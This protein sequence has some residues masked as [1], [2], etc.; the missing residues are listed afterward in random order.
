MVVFA[1]DGDEVSIM[2]ER[3]TKSFLDVLLK[4]GIPLNEPVAERTIC[5]EYP[6]RNL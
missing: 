5:N 6:R 4:A 1:R 2:A 3:D